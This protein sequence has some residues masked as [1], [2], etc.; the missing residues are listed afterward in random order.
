MRQLSFNVSIVNDD[1]PEDAEGFNVHLR[2]D[3]ADQ[4]RLGNC[5]RVTLSP[6]VA[7]VT[8]QDDEGN[9]WLHVLSRTMFCLIH[10]TI[11]Y[12]SNVM[13]NCQDHNT[14]VYEDLF[15]HAMWCV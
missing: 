2:L 4:A 11:C 12:L 5:T 15:H 6:E 14:H 10:V 13:M 7:T 3:P 9:M 1:I 8:I